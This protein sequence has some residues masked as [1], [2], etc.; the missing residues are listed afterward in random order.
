VGSAGRR[1]RSIAARPA[2]R[3]QGAAAANAHSATKLTEQ[4]LLRSIVECSISLYVLKISAYTLQ[5]GSMESRNC[6]E[7]DINLSESD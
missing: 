6:N 3:Q 4:R 7:I 5:S 2:P 1:Y